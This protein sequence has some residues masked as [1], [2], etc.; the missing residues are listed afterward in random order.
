MTWRFLRPDHERIGALPGMNERRVKLAAYYPTVLEDLLKK[1]LSNNASGFN[2]R[3]I[4]ELIVYYAAK[5]CTR[6]VATAGF[7]AVEA[8][9]Q[10]EGITEARLQR[11]LSSPDAFGDEVQNGE[12][13]RSGE[14][15]RNPV[16]ILI[17]RAKLDF[18]RRALKPPGF[19][20]E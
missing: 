6:D 2:E 16:E 13:G 9:K 18:I 3:A 17:C 12:V 14:R 8:L 19:Y 5:E 15:L 10:Q 1:C 20:E 7:A 11:L 4:A